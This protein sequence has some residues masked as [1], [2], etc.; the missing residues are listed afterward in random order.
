M[1]R[2][3]WEELN[4]ISKTKLEDGKRYIIT[5]HVNFADE[6]EYY[7]GIGNYSKKYNAF[8]DV[9]FDTDIELNFVDAF[10]EVNPFRK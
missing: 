3:D 1:G 8:M 6:T 4:E 10:A 2:I 9:E 5:Y 7:T